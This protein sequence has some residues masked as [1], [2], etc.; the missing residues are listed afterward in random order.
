MFVNFREQDFV[1]TGAK[2][3]SWLGAG[4]RAWLLGL[5]KSESRISSI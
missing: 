4:L 2:Y 1:Y 5:L 3:G